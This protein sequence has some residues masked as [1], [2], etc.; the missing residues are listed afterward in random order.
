MCHLLTKRHGLA[1]FALPVILLAMSL[2]VAAQDK[3]PE[4]TAAEFE[5]MVEQSVLRGVN[6]LR[7]LLYTS[8]AA[9]E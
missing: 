5:A 4:P 8:D 2:S 7:C 6:F 3:N 9:D 1:A